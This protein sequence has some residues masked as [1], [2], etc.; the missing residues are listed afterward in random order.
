MSREK[1]IEEQIEEISK[2]LTEAAH[3]ACEDI[4]F[5]PPSPYDRCIRPTME[6]HRC[7]EARALIEADYRK[8]GWI[9]VD[10]RLPEKDGD[11]ITFTNVTGSSK[12]VIA[13]HFVTKTVRGMKVR[14]WEWC[15]RISPWGVTHWMPMPEP[16]KMK[17]GE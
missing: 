10:E 14:R 1:Q 6:C 7:K 12:G 5:A 4:P 15:G 9:S 11:Y 17:G 2:I 3:K 13:M 16:P 8:Q